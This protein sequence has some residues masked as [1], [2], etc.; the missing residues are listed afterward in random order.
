[1]VRFFRASGLPSRR[2][3]EAARRRS[4]R[5]RD[6][7]LESLE[8]R[9]ALAGL[10]A[11][12]DTIAPVVRSVS[13]P[14]AGTY[15]T[16][17]AVTFKVTFS[18]PVLVAGDQRGLTLPVEVGY[19]MRE[20]QYVSGSGSKSLVF[21]MTVQAND[22]D[23]DG[24]S[25]GRVNSAA[26]RDFDFNQVN[27][28]PRILDRAG[29]PASNAIPALDTSRIRVDATGPVVASYGAFMTRGQ[30][31]ALQVTFD[32][33]VFV[34]GKPTLPVTIG[35][36]QRSLAYASGSGTR[37]LS[38]AVTLPK[39]ASVASPAFRGENG[40]PGEV[41]LL[42]AAADLEDRFGNSVTAIGGDYGKTYTDDGKVTGNR[43]VLLG[44]HFEKL[45]TVCR[46]DLDT[47]LNEEPLAFRKDEVEQVAE[48]QANF[49]KDYVPPTYRPVTSDVDVYRVAYRSTIPEQGN[50][51]TVA[52]GLV[53]IPTG[54]T[55]SLPLVS[56][57]HGM[58][59]LEAAVPSQA[60]S[61][62]A[63]EGST[64][65]SH[66]LTPKQLSDMN[67]DTRLHV[68]QFAGHGYAVIA[69]DLF[70]LGNSVENDAFW[71]KR[72]EQQACL[73]MHAA[74]QKLFAGLKLTTDRLFLS[75]A[76]QGGLVTLAF[77]E[78]LEARG[79]TIDGVSTAVASSDPE[80]L[81]NRMIFNPRPSS[82]TSVPDAAWN[83]AMLQFA[84]FS[85][86]GYGG[87]PGTA[88]ELF[89]GNYDFARKFY[90]REFSAL[91][92]F[93]YR[94]DVRGDRVPFMTM[95]GV[96]R[97]AAPAEFIAPPLGRDPRAF[98]ATT[99]AGL[100]RDAG[101]GKTRLESPMRMYYSPDDQV[102]PV[103]V[104]TALATW[105]RTTF[106]T[107]NIQLVPVEH[108]SHHDAILSAAFGQLEWF[109]DIRHG[110]PPPTP[111]PA[112]PGVAPSSP[113]PPPPA[114]PSK[115]PFVLPA[116][117]NGIV[118]VTGDITGDATF[119]AGTVYVI[120]GEVHVRRFVTL[121]IE[122]GVEVRI[123]NGRENFAT[124]T[125]RAL[126]F[127]SGSSLVAKHV[128]F[129][130]SDAANKP[131]NEADNG[132]VFFCG[133]TRKAAKDDVASIAIGPSAAWSFSAEG[134]VANHLGRKDPREGDGDGSLRDDIDAVSLVGVIADEWN[135]KAVEVN[136][137]GD[138]GFDLTL[139][140]VEMERV[141][142]V[143]PEEDG[144]N[145]SSSYLTITQWLEV[146]MTDRVAPEDREIFDFE[147]TA[148]PSMITVSRSAT[149][150]L[151]GF[152]DS[153]PDDRAIYLRSLDMKSPYPPYTR[154]LYVWSGR[155][156][157][158]PAQIFSTS[159]RP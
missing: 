77:Q 108:A 52:Y 41:I 4:Q 25:V 158:G 3:R 98:A 44:T 112:P 154:H 75:G 89:G 81:A 136:H 46:S 153:S 76:S 58:R 124:I 114:V 78:A 64:P 107:T 62:D 31:V 24:I 135:V 56:Y 82:T 11:L 111:T 19:A 42:N 61:W 87:K 140:D 126:I 139:S 71:T 116:A 57:Q 130:A 38:F 127:D 40:L 67:F 69:A 96:T 128:T 72:S 93:T 17:R 29:N 20:A 95:D 1:M 118:E 122:D 50:R 18:E 13:L 146:D 51:P 159:A 80:M 121:T 79:V 106:G 91:P 32:G 49:W 21:R 63:T 2:S 7:K 144:V 150:D 147:V 60:F 8:P 74:A 70:G 5:E 84:A 142:I 88:L 34:K 129:Q 143:D 141:T 97:P 157:K 131:V 132:G 66:G 16:D 103:A 109:D 48:G 43:V 54:A 37:T 47:I 137:S 65:V 86:G 117:V 145:L 104:S 35:G 15:G 119:K 110:F 83:V 36:Q 102:A 92:E 100:V 138:D 6:L 151:R 85:L 23:T 68:A 99:F 30:Q 10:Q 26:I 53:A 134:I 39:G 33:P 73:D 27:V 125:S 156:E 14:A 94:E 22:V 123:R 90:A 55:G 45:A 152:W 133:G 120:N 115:P 101:A 12:P 9:L 155:L 59:Y 149:V 148:V 28:A 105:Q 113:A